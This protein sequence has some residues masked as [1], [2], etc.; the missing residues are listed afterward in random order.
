M[1]LAMSE[2]GGAGPEAFE[3]GAELVG[4]HE[5]CGDEVVAPAD[6]RPERLDGVGLGL[7]CGQP[8][9]VGAQDVGQNEGIAGIALGGDGA[10]ARP[11]RL[12]DVGMDRRDEE[13]GL[14][15]HVTRSPLGRSMAIGVSSGGPCRR[16]RATRRSRPSRS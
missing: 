12:D 13:P 9:A 3:Q 2:A 4:E 1:G 7:Q 11:A 6:Q 5:P 10:V 16:R 14:D 8:M 15:Q